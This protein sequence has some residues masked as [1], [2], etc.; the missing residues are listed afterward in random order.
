MHIFLLLDDKFL[1]ERVDAFLL[2]MLEAQKNARCMDGA[3]Y[4]LAE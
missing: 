4:L 2:C 3:W 1:R